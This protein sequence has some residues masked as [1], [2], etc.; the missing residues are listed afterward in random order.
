MTVLISRFRSLFAPPR[1]PTVPASGVLFLGNGQH[2]GQSG[3]VG[4][5]APPITDLN[6]LRALGCDV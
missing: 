3:S 5:S 4:A 6:L 1:P 2:N